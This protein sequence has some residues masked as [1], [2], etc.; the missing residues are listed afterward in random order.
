MIEILNYYEQI[1]PN[2][3][4][5]Y[6]VDAKLKNGQIIRRIAH[7]ENEKGRWFN[8]PTYLDK[9]KNKYVPIVEF[10]TESHNVQ[11]F[12]KLSKAVKEFKGKNNI[13]EPSPLDIESEVPF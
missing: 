8:W 9:D 7:L 12:E 13:K 1:N 2:G 4:K 3:K 5:T 11:F 10:E 6:Y